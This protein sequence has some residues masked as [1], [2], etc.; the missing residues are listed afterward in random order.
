MYQQHCNNAYKELFFLKNEYKAWWEH[1]Q[2]IN[3]NRKPYIKDYIINT[4]SK[5]PQISWRDLEKQIR[6][7]CC[8]TTI[9]RWITLKNSYK[10]HNEGII[11]LLSIS[12]RRNHLDFPKNYVNNWGLVSGKYSLISYDEKCFWGIVMRRF[13]KYCSTI[14][15]DPVSYKAYHI[16][17]INTVICITVTGV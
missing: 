9:R 2:S 1:K 15:P 6:C 5:N 10:T 13:T 7:W 8:K 14:G 17:H 12:Q 3:L 4:L 16:K 11:T